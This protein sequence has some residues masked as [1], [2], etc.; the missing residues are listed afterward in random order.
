[1]SDIKSLLRERGIDY[2]SMTHKMRRQL[3]KKEKR[4]VMRQQLAKNRYNLA[5]EVAKISETVN[6]L[7]NR[8]DVLNEEERTFQEFSWVAR[9]RETISRLKTNKEIITSSIPVV[10]E[11]YKG[12]SSISL[13]KDNHIMPFMTHLPF[14]PDTDTLCSFFSK[15]G[16]CQFG[17]RCDKYHYYPRVSR[18]LV[19]PHLFTEIGISGSMVDGR[20]QDVELEIDDWDLYQCYLAFYKDV[21]LEVSKSGRVLRFEVCANYSSHLRGNVIVLFERTENAVKCREALNARWYNRRLVQCEYSCLEDFDR[22]I[23]QVVYGNNLTK[24][25]RKRCSRGKYCNF[26]HVFKRPK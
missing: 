8:L 25:S 9:E 22:A 13:I 6:H 20:E 15:T 5:L 7:E 14:A 2:L 26:W 3:F 24:W 1:M 23:C 18:T 10:K 21:Y 12:K 19:F 4:R 17:D 16:A 11:S